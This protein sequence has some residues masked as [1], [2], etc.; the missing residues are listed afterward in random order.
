MKNFPPETGT[1]SLSEF[2]SHPGLNDDDDDDTD[3]IVSHAECSAPG[4]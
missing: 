2:E 4:R 3:S 1:N